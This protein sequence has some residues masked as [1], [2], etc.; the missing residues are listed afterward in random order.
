MENTVIIGDVNKV[1]IEFYVYHYEQKGHLFG[2]LRLMAK[3]I[4]VGN[5]EQNV[6][7]DSALF[8]AK[9]FLWFQCRRFHPI[10]EGKDQQ[11]CLSIVMKSLY[12]IEVGD[13]E[14]QSSFKNME[15]FPKISPAFDGDKAILIDKGYS[16]EF[17]FQPYGSNV[18]EC[19]SVERDYFPDLL[20]KFI[21]YVIENYN[22]EG[23]T[24]LEDT[25][26]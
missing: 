20:K 19:V 12:D 17:I 22:I 13:T 5:F 6:L 14:M 4:P 2:R 21:V 25:Y 26:A 15:F 8:W 23:C 10:F 9:E 18:V 24:P 7:I 16:S 3:N 1:A 11:E